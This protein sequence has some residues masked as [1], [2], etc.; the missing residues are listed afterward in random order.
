[1]LILA[2]LT[3]LMNIAAIAVLAA[4]LFCK[5]ENPKHKAIYGYSIAGSTLPYLF[6][7]SALILTEVI[8]HGNLKFSCLLLCVI[9]PFIIGKIVRYE[10][11]KKYTFIQILCY[12][13]SL[14]VLVV[15]YL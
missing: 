1:M 3:I 15:K 9:S 13:A 10:T 7:L 12:C 11:L 6:L 8:L 2:I 5:F 4:G 14:A